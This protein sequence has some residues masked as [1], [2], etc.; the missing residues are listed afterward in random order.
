METQVHKQNSDNNLITSAHATLHCLTG[1]VIGEVTGLSIGLLLGLSVWS[2]I[3]LATSLAYISGFTLGLLP[4]MKHKKK[5]FLEAL[6]MIWL[7]EA[8]SIGVMEIVMNAV[9]YAMGGM[10]ADS[11]LSPIFWIAIVVAVIAGFLAA[12]PVNWWL[13]SKHLKKCH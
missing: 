1:C 5:S 12:W 11:I 6:K 9:D 4:V 2:T 7:G 10:Q 3:I 13:L 8:I